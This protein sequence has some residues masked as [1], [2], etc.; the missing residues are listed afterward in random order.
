MT[1]DMA[2]KSEHTCS[3][4]GSHKLSRRNFLKMGVGALS[5]LAALEIGGASFLFLQA[6]TQEGEIGGVVTAGAIDDFPL[7]SVTEF[8]A[9]GFFLIRAQDGGF[10]A[11]DRHCPHLGCVVEWVPEK[12]HFL[13]PCHASTFDFHGDYENPPVPRPLDTFGLQIKDETVL[14]DTSR[15]QE[16]EHFVPD[17]LVYA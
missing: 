16:R 5:A 4:G 3:C 11:V 14:V 17:Q 2:S 13:C 8:A 7:G 1:T 6:R 15:M 12:N 9:E 10:L